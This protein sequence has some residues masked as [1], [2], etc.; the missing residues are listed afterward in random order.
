MGH[1]QSLLSA[2]EQG[3]VQTVGISRGPLVKPQLGNDRFHIVTWEVRGEDR[4]M[5]TCKAFGR[6]FRKGL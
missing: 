2:A 4:D 5:T 3:A 1:V 6:E